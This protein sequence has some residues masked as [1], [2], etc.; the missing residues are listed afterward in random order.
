MGQKRVGGT[1]FQRLKALSSTVRPAA[2]TA[3][4]TATKTHAIR[5]IESIGLLSVL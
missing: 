4:V 2:C 5:I 1:A 3:T